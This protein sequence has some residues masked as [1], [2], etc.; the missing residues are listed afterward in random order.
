MKAFLSVDMEGICGIVN[1]LET[2]PEKG[3]EAYQASR[4]LMTGEANAAV[5]GCVRAGAK[6]ILVADSHW[7]FDNLIQEELHE[8]ATLLRGWPRAGS[9]V[10]GLD[11]TFAAALFVGYHAMAGTPRAILDHTFSGRIARVEINGKA[12]GE[13]G[14]NAALAGHHGVPVVLVTGDTAVT[15]EAK[16]LLSG[17]RLVAVK[18]AMGASAA[19]SM[20]PKLARDRIREEAEKACRAASGILPL[21]ATTPVEMAIEFKGTDHADRAEIVPGV[22][23]VGGTRIEFRGTD[24]IEAFRTFYA[25]LNL[26][27]TG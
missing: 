5:E 9:M 20:H 24:M 6:E 16:G 26:S 12:V 7:N 8:A 4:R 14:I 15:A 23:R 27:R 19:M 21:K 22:R 10:G 18:D 1:E 17:I 25:A 3:G 2:D 13:T 11:G